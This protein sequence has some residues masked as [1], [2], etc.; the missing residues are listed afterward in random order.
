MVGCS[1]RNCKSRSIKGSIIRFYSFPKKESVAN[2]WLRYCG[3][4]TK[5]KNGR[6]CSKHFT[7]TDYIKPSLKHILMKESPRRVRILKP[8]AIPTLQIDSVVKSNS[9]D[10]SAKSTV[11]TPG[12]TDNC[13]TKENYDISAPS[14]NINVK[15]EVH[16]TSDSDTT[17]AND[18]EGSSNVVEESDKDITV[19]AA[20]YKLLKRKVEVHCTSESDTTPANNVEGSSNVVEKRYY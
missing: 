15:V 11:C 19:S 9:T 13:E 4:K 6:V 8:D 17:P 1:I 20:E 10:L 3:L 18:V 14:C 5:C 12:Q 16:C 2:E 7:S